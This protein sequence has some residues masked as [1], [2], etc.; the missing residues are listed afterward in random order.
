MIKAK[1][2][3]TTQVRL[4]PDPRSTHTPADR[5]LG[6][7][8]A[9]ELYR[10][11]ERLSFVADAHTHLRDLAKDRAGKLAKDDS[12]RNRVEALAESLDKAHAALVTTRVGQITGEE[13]L[14]EKILALYGA[15]NGYSGRPTE[16]HRQQVGVLGKQL[17]DAAARL[18]ALVAK[19]LPAINPELEKNKI[20]PLAPLTPEEWKKKQEEKK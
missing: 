14:R 2:T 13:R 12:L 15:V 10:M 9:W 16:T 6:R 18:D 8:T 1:E 7:S 3:F 20:A 5:E 17:D 11:I 19:E 4:V